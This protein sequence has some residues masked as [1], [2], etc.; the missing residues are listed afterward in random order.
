MV[1]SWNQPSASSEHGEWL[2]GR[3]EEKCKTKILSKLVHH[4]ARSSLKE[5]YDTR[6]E[7]MTR[8]THIIAVRIVTTHGIST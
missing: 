8:E 6:L 4:A 5:L 3:R 7:W 1:E 2:G